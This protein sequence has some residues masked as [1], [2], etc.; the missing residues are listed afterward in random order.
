MASQ[1]DYTKPVYGNP[2]TQSVRDNFEYAYDEITA[3]QNKTSN[4]PFLPIAGG[5][6]DGMI[7]LQND[8][9]NP[10]EVVT[11]RYVDDLAFGNAGGGIPDAP[12]D[13]F[14][15]ARMNVTGGMSWVKNPK[16]QNTTLDNTFKFGLDDT[17]KTSGFRMF[18]QADDNLI[19]TGTKIDGTNRVIAEMYMRS[20]TSA[21]TFLAPLISAN[22]TAQNTLIISGSAPELNLVSS[23]VADEYIY[24]KTNALKRWA[25]GT[26]AG[27]TGLSIYNY[28]SG[29]TIIGKK[30]SIDNSGNVI[31]PNNLRVGAAV[32][33]PSD[34]V[35]AGTINAQ[36]IV[37]K[38]D[39]HISFNSY[40][41]KD[42]GNNLVWKTLESGYCSTIWFSAADGSL[43]LTV[44]PT[45]AAGTT[46]VS[47]KGIRLDQAGNF[48][49]NNGNLWVAGN[50]NTAYDIAA[51]NYYVNGTLHIGSASSNYEWYLN[52][53]PNGNH[54]HNHRANW[55]DVWDSNNGARSWNGPSGNLMVLD[56]VGNL[57]LAGNLTTTGTII[58]YGASTF[59]GITNNGDLNCWGYPI[60]CGQIYPVGGIANIANKSGFSIF[61]GGFNGLY[62]QF[63]ANSYLAK[64][65]DNS[66]IIIGNY[67]NGSV[68]FGT[69]GGNALLRNDNQFIISSNG[70]KPGGGPWAD[71]SDARI[72]QIH[73]NYNQGLDAIIKLNPRIYSFLGNETLDQIDIPMLN[74]VRV[75]LAKAIEP[76]ENPY[77]LRSF[78]S[79]HAIVAEQGKRYIGLVAQEVEESMPEMIELRAGTIDGEHVDDL[80]MMDTN[81]LI[82]A[83]INAF[84]E[85]HTRLVALENRT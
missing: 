79:D 55:Y 54:I 6:M 2:T 16:F 42:A 78:P 27:N 44:K 68:I 7:T 70:W 47:E 35:Y 51:T 58:A 73:G 71:G 23:T 5:I 30:F 60:Y 59:S 62:Y 75:R 11:K 64:N 34:S 21:F 83:T 39:Q 22:F 37:V 18:V 65:P 43:S 32:P 10:M 19:W 38:T 40:V 72:K 56:G 29:G 45:A 26:D 4:A 57:N 46:P 48:Y 66:D 77:P 80:R 76:L 53:D 85:I 28:D 20:D 74:A 49:V 8:P 15:Y 63:E 24:F 13:N 82:Y 69:V 31:I 67:N 41:G 36:E 81:A 61:T 14:A 84:K 3:L 52:I 9:E 25:F 12:A 1:I 17:T 50:I 33:I